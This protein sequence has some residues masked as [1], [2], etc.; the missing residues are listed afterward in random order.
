MKILK[1]GLTL[2]CVL[3]FSR[4]VFAQSEPS[5]TE[6][7]LFNLNIWKDTSCAA[8]G[9]G[10]TEA[11]NFCDGLIVIKNIISILFEFAIPL[12][13]IMIIYGGFKLMLAGGNEK[14]IKTGR[15]IM[16]NAAWGLVIVLASWVII[17]TVLQLLTGNPGFPW[18]RITC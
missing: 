5:S 1:I 9:E 12:T 2:L 14:S 10:P 18:A 6:N 4:I 7:G 15:D 8:G 16:T 11:C 13:V 17:N 3:A